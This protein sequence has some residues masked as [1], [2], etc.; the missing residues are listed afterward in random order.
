[1]SSFQF[2]KWKSYD[3]VANACASERCSGFGWRQEKGV[4]WALLR[5]IESSFSNY[6]QTEEDIKVGDGWLE[7]KEAEVC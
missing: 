5:D 4:S 2:G 6:I 7:P 1:M 3:E